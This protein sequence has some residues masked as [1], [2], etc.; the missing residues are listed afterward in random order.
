MPQTRPHF[1]P[2]FSSVE[3]MLYVTDM[4]RAAAFYT[5]KLGFTVA[6]MYGEPAYF[7]MVVRDNAKLCL[8]LVHEPVFAGDIRERQQLLSA[9]ITL[10]SAAELRQLHDD[11]QAAGVP[12][13]QPLATQPWGAQNFILR[14][15]DGNLI[16]FASP[17]DQPS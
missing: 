7:G 2:R 4:Q 12:F 17:A 8:R 3:A 10:A 16:L 5:A 13:H 11:Y 14:D 15:P 9:A 1:S 6:F